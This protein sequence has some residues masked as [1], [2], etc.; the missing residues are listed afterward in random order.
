MNKLWESLMSTF[1]LKE[2]FSNDTVQHSTGGYAVCFGYVLV[3]CRLSTW[4]IACRLILY[5][6]LK[7][8]LI[9]MVTN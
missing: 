3:V 8:I 5:M 7:K 1:C 2:Q 9:I 4:W 6:L